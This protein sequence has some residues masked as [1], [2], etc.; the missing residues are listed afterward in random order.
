MNTPLPTVVCKSCNIRQTW[1]NQENCTSCG[2]RM[3][4]WSVAS[5]LTLQHKNNDHESDGA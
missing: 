5:Q 1:R 2:R 3:S 4:N